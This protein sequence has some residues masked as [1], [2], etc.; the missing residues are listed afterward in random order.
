METFAIQR[1]GKFLTWVWGKG[2]R[3]DGKVI[4]D[5]MQWSDNIDR[6]YTWKTKKSPSSIVQLHKGMKVVTIKVT[7]ELTVDI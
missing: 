1:N 4:E 3:H 5:F 7:R 6:A 2:V